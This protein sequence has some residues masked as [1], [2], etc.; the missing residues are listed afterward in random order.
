MDQGL[1]TIQLNSDAPYD[2][3]IWC[4]GPVQSLASNPAEWKWHKIAHL[5]T[6]N[7]FNYSTRHGYCIALADKP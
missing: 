7:F 6:T 1:R 3:A 4:M 5:Q 2:G